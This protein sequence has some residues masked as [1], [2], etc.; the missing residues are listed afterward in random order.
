MG[1]NLCQPNGLEPFWGTK[2]LGSFYYLRYLNEI[3]RNVRYIHVMRH[4]LDMA[5]SN[6]HNQLLNW[7][8]YLDVVPEGDPTPRYLL[9]YWARANTHA[10]EGCE[11]HLPEHHLVV[12]FEDLCAHRHA[13]IKRIAEFLDVEADSPMIDSIAEKIVPQKSQGRYQRVAN[14]GMFDDADL[15][16]LRKL[17]F[18]VTFLD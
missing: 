7:G 18:S 10:L 14:E 15:E 9:K 16:I 13:Q 2:V 6:N 3:F 4:G 17:G 1:E 11:A 8:K 5:F 12:K